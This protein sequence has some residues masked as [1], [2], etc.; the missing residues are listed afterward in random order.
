MKIYADQLLD[1]ALLQTISPIINKNMDKL[2]PQIIVIK[3]SPVRKIYK[4]Q[5]GKKFFF[6]KHYSD[7]RFGKRLKNLFRSV[8]AVRS[9]KISKALI[10]SLLPVAEPIAAI[11]IQKNFYQKESYYL[12]KGCAGH[13]LQEFFKIC[14]QKILVLEKLAK[15]LAIFFRNSFYHGDLNLANI[16]VNADIKMTFIDV[17]NIKRLP[18]L[19]WSRVKRNMANFNAHMYATFDYERQWTV[20]YPELEHFFYTFLNGY[21]PQEDTKQFIHDIN[22]LT[23]KALIHWNKSHLIQAKKEL[24]RALQ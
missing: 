23:A 12:M 3:D 14:N 13:T 10:N 21:R 15:L 2:S 17:D 1:D 9:Y 7:Q 18:F 4:I 24:A 22:K 5:K 16:I 8:E 11:T 19:P 6:L 20:S